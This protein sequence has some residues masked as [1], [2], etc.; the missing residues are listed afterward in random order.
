MHYGLQIM[1]QQRHQSKSS[2]Q[3]FQEAVDIVRVGE[4]LGFHIAW[5][6]EHHFNNYSLCPSP[7]MMAAHCAGV[8]SKIRLGTGV[9]IAPLYNPARMIAEIAM[10]DNLSNGRLE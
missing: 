1:M 6:P 5:F 2:R 8:T 3:I 10:V 7:L 9:I 4:Q